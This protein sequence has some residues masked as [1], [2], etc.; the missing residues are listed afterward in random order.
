[1]RTRRLL[2]GLGLASGL[3]VIASVA[4]AVAASNTV[5]STRASDLTAKITANDL[6][7]VSALR[8]ATP[9]EYGGGRFGAALLGD[10][11]QLA[12]LRGG[13]ATTAP[14]IFASVDGF[15]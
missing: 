5:A 14:T 6:K 7:P 4:S 10:A 9:V 8:D 12:V 15:C 2:L 13:G 11:T 3:V 1:M